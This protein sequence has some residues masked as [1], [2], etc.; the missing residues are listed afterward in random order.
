MMTFIDEDTGI[1]FTT[2][3]KNRQ[4]ILALLCQCD[5][6]THAFRI[7]VQRDSTIALSVAIIFCVNL[8]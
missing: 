4:K 7:V 3:Q 2:F 5:G 8:I 6:N 1:T